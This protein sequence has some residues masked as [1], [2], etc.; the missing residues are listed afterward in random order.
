MRGFSTAAV[1]ETAE[2]SKV[3]FGLLLLLPGAD[4]VGNTL[5]SLCVNNGIIYVEII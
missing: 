2:K 4:M 1:D 3:L 5:E